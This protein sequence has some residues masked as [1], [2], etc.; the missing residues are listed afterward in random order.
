MEKVK[1]IGKAKLEDHSLEFESKLSGIEGVT[2][3]LAEA[4]RVDEPI[5]VRLWIGSIADLLCCLSRELQD[6][7]ERADKGE[8]TI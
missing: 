8:I 2:G 6:L 7:K 3:L 4:A 1:Q 5:E